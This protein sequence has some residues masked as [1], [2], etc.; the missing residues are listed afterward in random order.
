M[1]RVILNVKQVG[2][3]FKTVGSSQAD[4]A[5]SHERIVK[6]ASRRIRRDGVDN[7]S[8]AE[9]MNQAGL[10]HGG[11]YRHFD[12]RDELVAEAIEDAL[13]QGSERVH[14]AANLGG[15]GALAAIIDAYL[16]TLH[17]D[18]P[19]TGCAV[20]ALPTDISRTDAR[21]R[22]AYSRQVRTYLDLLAE[23]TPARDPDERH[24]I[25]AALLGALLLARAV[26]DRGL[27]DEMLDSV[28]RALHRYVD[29]EQSN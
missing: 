5:A 8:V 6:A 7:V 23:L 19:E 16:S 26:D 14:A 10:T 2:G 3:Q 11:F 20:A 21:A 24:L 12:S 13:A 27:S 25:L 22:A 9:L 18:K 1:I 28:A 15:D 17:R 29:A 4:K